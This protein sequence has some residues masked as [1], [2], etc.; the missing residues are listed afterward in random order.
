M[1][2]LDGLAKIIVEKKSEIE[3]I[4]NDFNEI[5]KLVLILKEKFQMVEPEQATAYFAESVQDSLKSLSRVLTI[6]EMNNK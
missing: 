3:A 6:I 5:T 4:K 1:K 2:E